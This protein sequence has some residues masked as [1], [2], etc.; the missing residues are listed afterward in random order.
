MGLSCGNPTAHA[1]LRA[2][3]ISRTGLEVKIR[4]CLGCSV[5]QEIWRTRIVRAVHLLQSS[6]WPVTAIAAAS[7]FRTAAHLSR[8]IKKYAGK[9]PSLFRRVSKR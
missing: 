2:V 3:S 5:N 7:G 4:R 9:P 6:D 1:S 8:V